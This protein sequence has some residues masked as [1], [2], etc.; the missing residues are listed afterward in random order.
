MGTVSIMLAVLFISISIFP[1][2]ILIH[3]IFVT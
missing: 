3:A 2:C 1:S